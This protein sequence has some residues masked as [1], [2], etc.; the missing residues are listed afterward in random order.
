MSYGGGGGNWIS[1]KVQG[2]VAG[3][4]DYAGGIVSGVGNGVSG[5]G[6]QA[7]QA[8]CFLPGRKSSAL[9]W[10]TVLTSLIE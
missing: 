6:Q 9:I 4:G 1:K 8:Y 10:S 7:S 5:A 2:V 3:A